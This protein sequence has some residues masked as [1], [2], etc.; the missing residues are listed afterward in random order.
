MTT[1]NKPTTADKPTYACTRCGNQAAGRKVR[2]GGYGP[3]MRWPKVLGAL[4]CKDCDQAAFVKRAVELPIIGPD[5]NDEWPRLRAALKRGFAEATSIMNFCT[6]ELYVRDVRRTPEMEKLPKHEIPYLYPALRERFP[7]AASGLLTACNQRALRCYAAKRY[8]ILWLGA[9]SLPNAK[10]PQPYVV[11]S[12]WR[13]IFER[14]RYWIKAAIAGE[15][16]LLL[17]SGGREFGYQ[18]KRVEQI[19]AGLAQASEL[20][21]REIAARDNDGRNGGKPNSSGR[22]VKRLLAKIAARFPIAEAAKREKDK[23]LE[24]RTAGDYLLVGILDG[25][26]DPIVFTGDRPKQ[27]YYAHERRAWRLS[28]DAK[29]ERRHPHRRRV[30]HWEGFDACAKKYRDR[31]NSFVAAIVAEIAGIVARSGVTHVTYDDERKDFLPGFVWRRLRTALL[32]RLTEMGIH[33][34][35]VASGDVDQEKADPLAVGANG[36]T[37]T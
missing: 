6:T 22:P 26:D 24:L 18:K 34:N 21:F 7:G 10:Y 12:G 1:K 8:A 33:A 30:K 15:K 19:V 11:P 2:G 36:E 31:M 3:P 20:S 17:L 28:L 25:R 5:G 14:E 32:V 29:H 9:E 35:F 16:F 13:L 4:L 37:A 23:L 27:W